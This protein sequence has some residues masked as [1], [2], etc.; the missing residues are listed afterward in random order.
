MTDE[1]YKIQNKDAEKTILVFSSIHTTPGRFRFERQLA[2][3]NV[4]AVFLNCPNNSWYLQGVPGLGSSMDESRAALKRLI[5]N[6]FPD[7]K[8]YALGSSMG[9]SGLIGLAAGL[10]IENSFAFC[11]EI[12]LFGKYSFSSNYYKGPATEHRDLWA[13][14][15]DSQNLKIFYGEECESDL[16]Q[17]CS[18][19]TDTDIPVLTFAH[20]GHGTIEAIFL[21][22]GMDGMLDSLLN[23]RPMIPKIIERGHAAGSLVTCKTLWK[24]YW[25]SKNKSKDSVVQAQILGALEDLSLKAMPDRSYYALIQYWRAQLTNSKHEKKSLLENALESAPLSLRTASAY[26]KSFGTDQM[27]NEFKEKFRLR[28]GNRYTDHARA[29][30]IRKF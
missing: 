5:R 4:N 10:E 17:L 13:E 16:N 9:A 27:K 1:Y 18:I 29:E 26:F 25:F 6:S 28:Y 24:S 21:S 22:E 15:A 2:D 14:L 19:K 23:D 8:I 20:E 3:V 30:P 11:P 12:D 7:S